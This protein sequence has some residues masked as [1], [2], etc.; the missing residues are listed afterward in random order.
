MYVAGKIISQNFFANM[1]EFLLTR[2][3]RE[4]KERTFLP[5]KSKKEEIINICMENKRN[6]YGK[7]IKRYVR[8]W[9]FKIQNNLLGFWGLGVKNGKKWL[10]IYKK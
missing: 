2:F 1:K 5:Q 3:K 4:Q 10:T 8:V 9:V 7:K 6:D